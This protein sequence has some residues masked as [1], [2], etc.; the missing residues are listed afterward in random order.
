MHKPLRFLGLSHRARTSHRNPWLR[1]L[2]WALAVTCSLSANAQ[3]EKPWGYG[4]P[5]YYYIS[6]NGGLGDHI[7][8]FTGSHFTSPEEACHEF[9]DHLDDI[10]P[11]YNTQFL[12]VEPRTGTFSHWADYDDQVCNMETERFPPV[13]GVVIDAAFCD[14][15]SQV[16]PDKDNP[17][18]MLCARYK[19]PDE[20]D[21][22]SG[23][24]VQFS[25]GNKVISETDFAS[26]SSGTGLTFTRRWNSSSTRWAFS[27]RQR[28]YTGHPNGGIYVLKD[29]GRRER[30]E[31]NYE[32]ENPGNLN[33]LSLDI[34]TSPPQYVYREPSGE[35]QRFDRDTEQLVSIEYRTGETITLE[36]A[37]DTLV[38]VR[39]QYNNTLTLTLD[40]RERVIAMVDPDG[41]QYS[42]VY[43]ANGED[44]E[45]V[46]YPDDTPGT[47]GSNPLGEDN[48]YKQYHYGNQHPINAHRITS[49]TDE[50]GD[51]YKTIDYDTSGRAI[52]SG[53]STGNIEGTTFDYTHLDDDVDPRVRVTN[54]L[55][56]D[57]V[58]HLEEVFDSTKVRQVDGIA[59]ANCLADVRSKTY[60]P[61]TGWLEREVDR[62]GNTTYYEYYTDPDHYGL[63]SKRVEAENTPDQQVY[64][65]DYYSGTQLLFN[66]TL[67]GESRTQYQYYSN[68]QVSRKVQAAELVGTDWTLVRRWDYE[69]TYHDPGT[70][71]KVATMVED[72]PRAY[73]EFEDGPLISILDTTTY[74]YSSQG[75]LT[76]ITNALG[77]STEYKNHNSRGKPRQIVD[78]NGLVLDLEYHP[79]GW[80]EE[81][82]IRD[83]SGNP[84]LSSV[85]TF[86]H[87]KAGQNTSVSLPNGAG[88]SFE[89][90]S[91][92]R[93]TAIVNNLG[94]RTE[95]VLDAASNRT[96]TLIKDSSGWTTQ[97]STEVY[98]ELSRLIRT[99][100]A[101][102]QQNHFGYDLNDNLTQSTD[103]KNNTTTFG[104]DALN[105]LVSA[106]DPDSYTSGYTYDAQGRIHTVTDQRGLI[107]TYGYNGFGYLT[108]LDSPDTGLTTYVVDRAG[109][110]TQQT[111]ARGVV[112]DYTYDTLN[113]LTSVRYPAT[114]SEDV[115][116]TY[117]DT[118]NGNYGLGR[119]TSTTDESGQTAYQY[120]HRGNIVGKAYT[121]GAT[122]YTV[123][124]AYDLADNIIQ[125][126][127]PSGRIV[128][129][130]RD[131]LGR[132]SG[133]TTRASAGASAAQVLSS[134]SYEPFGPVG[135]Y[136]YGNGATNYI[137]YDGDYR[138]T[139][140]DTFGLFPIVVL[141]YYYDA[142]N[143][144][145]WMYDLNDPSNDQSFEYDKLDR[146]LE[147]TGAYGQIDYLYDGVGNRTQKTTTNLGTITESYTYE[148]DSNRLD[149]VDTDDGVIQSQRDLTYDAAGRLIED[150]QALT[151]LRLLSYNSAGRFSTLDQ[152]ATLR[153]EYTYNYLGQRVA[154]NAFGSQTTI[155]N[156][157][158]YDRNGRLVGISAHDGVS[159]REYIYLDNV[160]VAAL[161]EEGYED[162]VLDTPVNNQP[163][164][165]SISSPSDGTVITS[166]N[167]VTLSG[168]SSDPE[169]GDLTGS[170]TWSS[171]L[172]GA[173]G[174]GTGVVVSSLSTG[175]HNITASVTDS[176]GLSA[177]DAVSLTVNA[178]ANT[179]P[180]V[181]ISSPSDG[182]II[183]FGESITLSG[184]SNDAE[185]GDLT[186]TVQWDS[187][188]DGSLGIGG[189]VTA[190]G[191]SMGD[192]I[193]TAS[194]TDTG[195]LTDSASLSLTVYP[196]VGDPEIAIFSPTS[197]LSITEGDS[198]TLNG[199]ATDGTDLHFDNIIEWT[200]NLDGLLGVGVDVVVSTLSVGTHVITAS[201]DIGGG[202]VLTTDV[203]V[204]VAAIFI[205]DDGD[206]VEN[207]ADNCPNDANPNQ[208][209]TDGDSIGNACDPEQITLISIATE[210]GWVRE[211]GED[212]NVGSTTNFSNSGKKALRIGD[213]KND[214]QY[215]AV[216]SFDVSSIPSN[217]DVSSAVLELTSGSGH[218]TGDVSGF[219][220]IEMD[221]MVGN[222][223]NDSALQSED[224]Q[225]AA[226]QSA[227]GTLVDGSTATGILNATGVQAVEQAISFTPAKVQIRLAFPIDDNDNATNDY[228]GYYSSDNGN[229]TRHPRLIIDYLLPD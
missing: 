221:I 65:F 151:G 156:H 164:Q 196:A 30:F 188:L 96:Q 16:M 201:A 41:H 3:L 149:R 61:A 183:Y 222:L 212:T 50:N 15:M 132:V 48:P 112:T 19:E 189:S 82:I 39:D 122:N 38:Y 23:N 37:S 46:I 157:Y 67:E 120:D 207:A 187:D 84:A 208:T 217:A 54:P 195:G 170:M 146:L 225:F 155:N 89:Y 185:D 79:R 133:I 124:Y 31:N 47:A 173:L 169:D 224:F 191:L 25:T 200:S 177:S 42:Y 95:Y 181:S 62:E 104:F 123:G 227:V 125:M 86:T 74:E 92:H 114:P 180:T 21:A 100:G 206:G 49:I 220:D 174:T 205:D 209:D 11:W 81:V 83:P 163:P 168:S 76:K 35:I 197:G 98:D 53:L 33:T 171:N 182:T 158:H 101:D 52:S 116:Y 140:I 63:V 147:A 160:M 154:R 126:L 72:G 93:L 130:A 56:K 199:T 213:H 153:A 80:L 68:G 110:R 70:D 109:N 128:D 161:I 142:N 14:P 13:P 165:V 18:R 71:S 34:S 77:H 186:S 107:T 118:A 24:P 20:C 159:K 57:S 203:T 178:A 36:Y 88:Y 10:R 202:T 17:G 198:I 106:L 138:I 90:D 148:P 194:V 55:G 8:G 66:E 2:P 85:Y 40:D 136:T 103:G 43:H 192:H 59:S 64:L 45:F 97:S 44:L 219:G 121:I 51:L 211:S 26:V 226:T 102:G 166:G 223:S 129:Y 228:I 131:S 6:F 141:D 175:N 99:I 87:D 134:I 145:S 108:S 5:D 167:S 69:Y 58:Y 137:Y 218:I 9:I 176:G 115:I 73:R 7:G 111:D 184:T 179:A 12:S 28:I 60:Y 94:E 135:S 1:G 127:Y 144:I 105:R 143:N 216:V 162:E 29:N 27:Y 22:T 117:D 4:A 119:L 204:T 91:G 229:S 32:P 214:R 210:D 193:I 152:D 150:N 75:L 172:D 139:D 113:R 78:M 190:S 215:K